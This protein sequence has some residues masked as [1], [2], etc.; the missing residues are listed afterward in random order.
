MKLVDSCTCREGVNSISNLISQTG[1]IN[2]DFN[3]GKI[4]NAKLWYTPLL[5]IG[6]ASGENQG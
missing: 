5:G 6:R 4:S 2:A 1:Y 3:D